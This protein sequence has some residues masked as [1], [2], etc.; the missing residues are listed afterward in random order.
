MVEPLTTAAAAPGDSTREGALAD[1]E[2]NLL[3]E[4]VARFAG[5]DF[6]EYSQGTLKRRVSERMRG[7]GVQTISGLQERILHDPGAFSRFMFAMSGGNGE[8]FRDGEFFRVLRQSVVPLLRTYSFARVWLPNCG[9]GED[10]YSIAAVLHEEGLLERTMIYATDASELALTLAKGGTFDLESA[11]EVRA[12]HRATGATTPLAEVASLSGETLRFHE[13]LKKNVIFAQHS[14]VTDGSLNEFHVIVARGV[15]PQFNK[16]LQFRVHNL[17]LGS[18]MRL[19]FL[20]LG[21]H[22]TLKQTPHER[23]FREVVRDQAVYRRMR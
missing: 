15:L 21:T 7:E 11:D 16:A 5:F 14:L 13:S 6:R 3:L 22:E 18:L 12:A 2:L 23:I 10:A 9:R 8:L 4:A 17:F 20:C 1:L 19:G